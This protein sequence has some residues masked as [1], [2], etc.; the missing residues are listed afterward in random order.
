MKVSELINNDNFELLNTDLIDK[1]INKVFASDLMSHVM[2]FAEESDILITVLNNINVMG[3]ASLLDFSG[4]IFSHNVNVNEA[5]IK[6]A[7]E[8]EIPVLKT[9]LTTSET[10][11]LLDKLGV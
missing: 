5:I 8:L 10:V 4:V 3:V 6:K 7:N 1:E 2:G 9:S 11:V